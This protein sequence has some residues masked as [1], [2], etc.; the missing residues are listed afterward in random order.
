MKSEV[1]PSKSR[2]ARFS[3]VKRVKNSQLEITITVPEK[4]VGEV[5]EKV[6]NEAAKEVEV[7]GFRKGQ[8][9][10]EMARKEINKDEARSAALNRL[11]TEAYT[12]AIKEHLLKPIANPQIKV[13]QFEPDSK[14]DLVFK[15]TTAE[16]PEVELGDY[17]GELKKLKVKKPAEGIVGPDGKP[18]VAEDKKSTEGTGKVGV[19][20]VLEAVLKTCKV[21][22][23]DILTESE[24]IRMLSRL[25]D[26]TA[27]LGLTVEQYLQSAGKTAEQIREEY[28]SQAEEGLKTE[29]VLDEIANEQNIE[30]SDEEIKKAIKANPDPKARKQFEKQENKWYIRSILRRNKTIQKLV[31]MARQ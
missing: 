1:H 17:K 8:A 19:G 30:V 28:K 15:A 3:R 5:L 23:P 20:D 31:E 21:E 12:A 27:R 7:K 10:K 2:E 14:K 24:V 26:Q 18:L 11:V 29:L 25:M 13:V 22:I 4:R 9:P 6:F 16:R